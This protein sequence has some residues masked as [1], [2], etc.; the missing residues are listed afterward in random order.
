ML[1]FPYPIHISKKGNWR[2]LL[3]YST[4]SYFNVKE[5]K[6]CVMYE[7][8]CN[9]SHSF[10][11]KVETIFYSKKKITAC[12]LCLDLHILVFYEY[13]TWINL[14]N[15]HFHG[16]ILLNVYDY[17]WQCLWD[18][19]SVEI[20]IKIIFVLNVNRNLNEKRKQD[21]FIITKAI[22]AL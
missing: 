6:F 14:W 11:F 20:S 10:Y 18:N 13:R 16:L 2:V 19:N 1:S 9:F 5:L 12:Q 8:S 4:T 15:L 17:L 7:L 22:V 21:H 3:V